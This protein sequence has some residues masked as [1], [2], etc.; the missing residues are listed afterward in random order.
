MKFKNV[1]TVKSLLKGRL[2]R[3]VHRD[4]YNIT[5]AIVVRLNDSGNKIYFQTLLRTLHKAGRQP[6]KTPNEPRKTSS[7]PKCHID[8]NSM[9]CSSIFWTDGKNLN[10][11]DTNILTFGAKKE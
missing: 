1:Y 2:A 3:K 11:L 6:K 9:F 7:F 10:F 5:M 8:K 4:L